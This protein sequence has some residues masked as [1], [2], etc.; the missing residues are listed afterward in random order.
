MSEEKPKRK[1][2]P[3]KFDPVEAFDAIVDATS[4]YLRS[5]FPFIF[6]AMKDKH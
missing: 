3:K 5:I 6:L 2:S 4:Q 1:R